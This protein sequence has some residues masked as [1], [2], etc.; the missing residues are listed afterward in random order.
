MNKPKPRQKVA[1]ASKLKNV[2]HIEF[3]ASS[4]DASEFAQFGNMYRSGEKYDLYV[5]ARYDFN[6]VLRYITNYSKGDGT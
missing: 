3:W 5:D 6:E 4:S 2:R 1:I